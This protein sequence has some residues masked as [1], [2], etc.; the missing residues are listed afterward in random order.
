MKK[1]DIKKLV[2]ES[3]KEMRGRYGVHDKYDTGHTQTR[4]L[5]GYPG[6]WEDEK[7]PFK[8]E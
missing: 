8:K 6:V 7:K 3:I 2:K 1:S 5:S 4:N